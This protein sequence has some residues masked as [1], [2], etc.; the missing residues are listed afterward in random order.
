MI[1][2]SVKQLSAMLAAKEISAVEMASE[3]LARAKAM[4][5][6]NAFITLDEDKTLAEAKAADALLASGQA[7]VLTGVPIA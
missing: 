6:L 2:K 7:G 5:D 3:Y 1:E 4:G